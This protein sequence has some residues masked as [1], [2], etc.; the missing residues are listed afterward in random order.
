MITYMQSYLLSKNEFMPTPEQCPRVLLSAYQ[1]APRGESVSQIGWQWYK[2]L[3]QLLPVT[4]VT[5]IRN[6]NSLEMAG[7]PFLNT[8]IIYIDTEWFAGPLYRFAIRL[9]PRS[10]HAA[11]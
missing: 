2:N 7:A 4:L 1:C 6:K 5:H 11:F 9:F 8:E 10:E 3:A